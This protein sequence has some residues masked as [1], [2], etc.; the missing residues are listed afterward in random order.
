MKK[1]PWVALLLSLIPGMGQIYNG[2]PTKGFLFLT[3]F[4]VAIGSSLS[5]LA[6]MTWLLPHRFPLPVVPVPPG[7]AVLVMLPVLM[8]VAANDAWKGASRSHHWVPSTERE[9]N[10]EPP[11]DLRGWGLALMVVGGGI[12]LV[13]T[14]WPLLS[15]LRYVGPTLL[16]VS[17]GYFLGLE[18]GCYRPR[19]DGRVQ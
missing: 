12:W 11:T 19:K 8:L 17:G 6:H 15:R 10:D 18:L 5:Q 7:F 9:V 1:N 3:A 16:V 4:L 2:E 13:Q 14:G